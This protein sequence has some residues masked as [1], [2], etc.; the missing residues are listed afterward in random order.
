VLTG[1]G[2]LIQYLVTAK[3]FDFQ[4]QLEEYEA[5]K[6]QKEKE[7]KEVRIPLRSPVNQ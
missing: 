6:A 3:G 2:C 7:G 5:A 1:L 4:V